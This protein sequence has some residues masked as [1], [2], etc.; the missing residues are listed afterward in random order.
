MRGNRK[1]EGMPFR[2]DYTG[3][4]YSGI[5]PPEDMHSLNDTSFFL[6]EIRIIYPLCLTA[7]SESQLI[8]PSN[9][10]IVNTRLG[11]IALPCS[12]FEVHIRAFTTLT[13][14]NKPRRLA[15]SCE[16][17]IS[18]ASR[19]RLFGFS[20]HDWESIVRAALMQQTSAA[21]SP[22]LMHKHRV[23]ELLIGTRATS[24][25]MLSTLVRSLRPYWASFSWL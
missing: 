17:V 18:R 11:T 15:V 23:L 24:S 16:C 3:I 21:K 22:N 4:L 25:C 2:G 19:P 13:R 20:P 1:S 5:T 6:I 10:P 14:Q 12:I 7:Y 8:T 9:H